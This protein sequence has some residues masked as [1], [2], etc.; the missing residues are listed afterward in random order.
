MN[1]KISV[2]VPVYN[3]EEYL[4]EAI[5][6]ILIHDKFLFELIIINDGSTDNSGK[7]LDKL[8]GKEKKVTIL[9]TKNNGQGLARNLG[10]VKAN[11]EYLYFFDSDDIADKNLFKKFNDIVLKYP[12]LEL[13]CFSGESFLDEKTKEEQI[14][15]KSLLSSSAYKRKINTLCES[16]VKA[17]NLLIKNN[18]FFPGPPF[19]ILKK[20]I[21]EKNNIKFNSIRYEDEEF[22]HKLFLFSGETYITNDVLFKRR[23]R[24]G[25]TMQSAG[26]F[27]DISGYFEIV[28]T[29]QELKKLNFI[30]TETK[31]TLDLR[32]ENFLKLI[33][34]LKTIKKIKL[35]K[36]QLNILRKFLIPYFEKNKYL[37]YYYYKF[38]FLYNLRILKKRIFN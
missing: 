1:P 20:S 26:K 32:I 22:T 33:I 27:S 25:S 31:E 15:K 24:I 3:T 23:V 16:G 12:N 21:L 34:E 13:F 19:Y 18:G 7:L 38:P 35:S 9:H 6:S 10:M 11:G 17:F 8:Y 30:S 36:E 37:L 14:I 28:E 2:I 4:Q 29:L 5:D